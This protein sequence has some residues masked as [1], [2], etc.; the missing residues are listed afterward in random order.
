MCAQCGGRKGALSVPWGRGSLPST[1]RLASAPSAPHLLVP[2][3]SPPHMLVL[4]GGVRYWLTVSLKFIPGSPDPQH[5]W[6]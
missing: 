3:C 1:A 6:M 5:L 4:P 2:P